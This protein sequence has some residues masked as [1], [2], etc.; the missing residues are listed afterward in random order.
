MIT[1]CVVA[2][3]WATAGFINNLSGFGA[4]MVALPLMAFYGLDMK[5]AAP[6]A[7]N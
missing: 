4:A 1:S 7:L 3:I 2:L 5:T 6:A